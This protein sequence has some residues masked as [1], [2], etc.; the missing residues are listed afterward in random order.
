MDCASIRVTVGRY[1]AHLDSSFR[2]LVAVSTT[3]RVK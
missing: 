3:G 1:Q 2:A